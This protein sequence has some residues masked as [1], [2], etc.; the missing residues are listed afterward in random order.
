[1]GGMFNQ[2]QWAVCCLPCPEAATINLGTGVTTYTEDIDPQIAILRVPDSG[3]PSVVVYIGLVSGLPGTIIASATT[4]GIVLR[5]NPSL[6]AQGTWFVFGSG[7]TAAE[8]TKPVT[9]FQWGGLADSIA[10]APIVTSQV[11]NNMITD[12]GQYQSTDNP[13][14]IFNA[15][16][17][18]QTGQHEGDSV[19][20]ATLTLVD[21]T[22]TVTTPPC[23]FLT[24]AN[25]W[26]GFPGSY[27]QGQWYAI[28]TQV[29][30]GVTYTQTG[31]FFWGT[32]PDQIAYCKTELGTSVPTT[33]KSL[34]Q[35]TNA[36]VTGMA[37]DVTT[38]L[39]QVDQVKANSYNAYVFDEGGTSGK[40]TMYQTD[41]TTPICHWLCYSDAARTV[42]ATSWSAVVARGPAVAG[43]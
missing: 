6:F 3:A 1:M 37:V 43:P 31:S 42:L 25:I 15:F 24:G 5:L 38:L 2:S 14:V 10:V 39:S 19:T 41:G 23:T 9:S 33:T 17:N 12:G 22:N 35:N 30:N 7:S 4:S 34:V 20:S 29:I 32:W 11:A 16:V 36:T 28:L 26:L 21:P 13:K 18:P 40:L 27:H 8:Y